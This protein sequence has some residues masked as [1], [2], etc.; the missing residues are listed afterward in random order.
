MSFKSFHK[1]EK[2]ILVRGGG[3]KASRYLEVAVSAEGGQKGIIR[4]PKGHGGW[5]WHRFASELQE[6]WLS[7]K[8]KSVLKF[9]KC[10]S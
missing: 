5:C 8:L 3:N 7:S 1:D 6:R 9:L 2:M 10:L 4:L